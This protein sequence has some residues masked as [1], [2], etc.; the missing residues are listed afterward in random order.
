MPCRVIP[1]PGGGAAIICGGRKRPKCRWC[2]NPS[3]KLCDF[4]VFGEGRKK[5]CSAPVCQGHHQHRGPDYD[6][7]PDHYNAR[8]AL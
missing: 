4:P 6:V 7:C 8:L 2:E 5:T 3:T 1:F